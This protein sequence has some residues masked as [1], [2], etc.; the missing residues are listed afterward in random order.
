M[1][2]SYSKRKDHYLYD[3]IDYTTETPR[4]S[5]LD[6]ESLNNGIA[7]LNEYGYAVFSNVSNEQEIEQSKDLLWKFMDRYSKG[8]IQRNNP[9]TWSNNW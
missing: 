6:Q 2:K 4:F 9:D 7:Y 3:Q 1:A 8:A 5:V